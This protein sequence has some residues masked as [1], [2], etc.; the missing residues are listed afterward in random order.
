MAM[1]GVELL[2]CYRNSVELSIGEMREITVIISV[3]SRTHKYSTASS[4]RRS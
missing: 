4:H 1:D 2:R 3:F